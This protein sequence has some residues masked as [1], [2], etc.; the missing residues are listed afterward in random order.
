MA[1]ELYK[2]QEDALSFLI[3]N[4][5]VGALFMD[6]GCGK[7]LIALEAFKALRSRIPLLKMFVVSPVS[8]LDEAWGEDIKK[9]TDFTYKN[10]RKKGIP[11]NF[12]EDIFVLNY[13]NTIYKAKLAKIVNLFKSYDVMLVA[14]ES[15]RMKNSKSKT[16]KALHFLRDYVKHRVVMSATPAPN[17]LMEY[18]GQIEFLKKHTLHSKPSAFKNIFFH[19]ER[20]NQKSVA[21]VSRE[22][23]REMHSKGWKYATTTDN[24]NKILSLIKPLAFYMKKEDCLDLP[25]RVYEIRTVE[26]SPKQKSAYKEMKENL[27]AEIKGSFVTAPIALTKLIKLREIVSGFAFDEKGNLLEIENPKKFKELVAVL[28]EIGDKQV[29]IWTQF[30]WEIRKIEEML[31]AAGKTVA[32]LYGGT[33]NKDESIQKFKANEVQYLIAHPKSA[34]HG[35]TFVNCSYQVFFSI[36][37]SWESYEQAKA[38]IHRIGQ[39]QKC[40]YIHI[41]AQDTIDFSMYKVLKTKGD[42]NQIIY[43]VLKIRL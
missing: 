34:A 10:C 24:R 15:S 33:K 41:L 16:T 5:G 9:F 17:S 3:K 18:W 26:L 42:R 32:T 37:Y 31:I 11:D 23:I 4:N 13:E 14:D 2:H 30:R 7:T 25:D 12:K 27:I 36:D 38:R 19:M 29:M 43:D 39:T 28:E 6:C 1:Y 22:A 21:P 35:L 20:N 8:L 40:T